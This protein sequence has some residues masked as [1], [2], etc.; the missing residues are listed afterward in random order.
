MDDYL[1]LER[2]NCHA[3]RIN[4]LCEYLKNWYAH[5]L[6]IIA[7]MLCGLKEIAMTTIEL[8]SKNQTTVNCGVEIL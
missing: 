5:S 3:Y 7:Q 6:T 8:Q 1:H 4:Y 2:S